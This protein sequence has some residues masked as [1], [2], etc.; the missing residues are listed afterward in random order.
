M[1]SNMASNAGGQRRPPS[2]ANPHPVEIPEFE[3]LL[4]VE[5]FGPVLVL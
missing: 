3:D 2:L 5:K 4:D 1:A